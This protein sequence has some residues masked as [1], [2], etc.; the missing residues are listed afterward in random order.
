MQLWEVKSN[1]GILRSV[2][3]TDQNDAIK[4]GPPAMSPVADE[5]GL[6]MVRTDTGLEHHYVITKAEAEIL[7][8]LLETHIQY[9]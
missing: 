8:K 5:I 2:L 6:S 9:G 7:I 1:K 4:L 3:V